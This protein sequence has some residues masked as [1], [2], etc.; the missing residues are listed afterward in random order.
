MG[1]AAGMGLTNGQTIIAKTGTTNL[2]QSAFFLGATPRDAMAVG[3][4]VNKP[5]CPARLQ[6]FCQSQ[7]S[8]AYKPPPGV[9][10]L[11]GVGGFAGYGG[12][13]PTVIWHDF[14]MKN[15]N[16]FPPIPWM[17]P[18]NDGT[19]WNLVGPFLRTKPKSKHTRPHGP[20]C[21][22]QGNGHGGPNK[23]QGTPTPTPTGPTPTPTPSGTPTPTP[24]STCP[25]PPT[26]CHS[27]SPKPSRGP[28]A[29]AFAPVAAAAAGAPLAMLLIV[30]LGPALPLVGRLR[31][32]RRPR[33]PGRS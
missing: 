27:H 23:C 25:P 19:T 21:H 13:W 1:T 30:V 18:N 3:M 29:A 24:T 17:Q 22:G 6:Q 31:P 7:Q 4:F 10:T 14:F 12:E 5:K 8:L 11:F 2:A 32:R 9:Q 16:R 28:S 20:D 33:A 15:F 26:P